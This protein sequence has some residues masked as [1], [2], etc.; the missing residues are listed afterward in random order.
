M[1]GRRHGGHP[2][3]RRD[4]P[5]SRPGRGRGPRRDS[6]VPFA[7]PH[8]IARAAGRRSNASPRGSTYRCSN[9]PSK[10][11]RTAQ[12]VDPLVRPPRRHGRRRPGRQADRAA[13][14]QGPRPGASPTSTGSKKATLADLDRMGKKSAHGTWSKGPEWRARR[15]PLDRF[16]TGLTIRHVG[17]RGGGSPGRAIRDGW[18]R[19]SG[20]RLWPIWKRVPEVGSCGREQR[21]RLLPGPEAESGPGRRPPG[22]S[23]SPRSRSRPPPRPGL[24]GPPWPA[25]RWS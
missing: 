3:G 17:T 11:P 22:R 2:E 16:L 15:R 7:L 9:P 14:R 12:G 6:E 13:R 1:P 18:K 8:R 19:R 4:H 24:A 20:P 23:A 25:S 5:A 21:L 10:L